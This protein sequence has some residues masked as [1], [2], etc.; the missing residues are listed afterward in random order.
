M[1]D[2]VSAP[3]DGSAADSLDLRYRRVTEMFA[4]LASPVRAAIIHLLSVEGH[5]VSALVDALGIS[6]PLASQHLRTLRTAGLVDV[7]RIGRT[8]VYRL[9][10]EHVAHIFLDAL[11]HSHEQPE[12][13]T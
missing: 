11:Q 12:A 7:E 3:L 9:A 10:D 6:Q 8:S 5:T 13:R 2:R 1:A 4:A